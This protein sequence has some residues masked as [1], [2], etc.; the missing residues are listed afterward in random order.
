MLISLLPIKAAD[1]LVMANSEQ[2]AFHITNLHDRKSLTRRGHTVSE[3]VH[4]RVAV[5]FANNG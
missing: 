2:I 5:S 1:M 4:H 3:C